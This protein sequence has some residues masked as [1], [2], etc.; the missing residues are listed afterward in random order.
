MKLEEYLHVIEKFLQDYLVE[1]HTSGYVLG[2]SGGVDSS[3]VAALTQKAVGNDK[4]T[5]IMMP[6]ESNPAD[7]KDATQLVEHLGLRAYTV[8][9]TDIYHQYLK[10]FEK[11]GIELNAGTKANLKA[12]IRMSILYAHAQML[13]A[14]VLGTDNAPETYTGYFTKYGDG[15]VDLLP[16]VHLM[17]GEV[18]EAAKYYNVPKNLAER[19]PTAGL[20]EGQTD[21]KEMGITY[22]ELDTFLLGG[23]ISPE[24][25]A[26]AERLHR[27]SEHKRNPLPRPIPFNRD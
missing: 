14:L 11:L 15:G 7:L 20:F 22:K 4:L 21:E 18:V 23:E 12:R 6:I 5:V 26:K 16:I 3:L 17:K 19:V 10:E 2:L 13:N 1:S 25:K 9:G 8:D 27:I 24:S